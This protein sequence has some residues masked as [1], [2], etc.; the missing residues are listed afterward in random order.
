MEATARDLC[1]GWVEQGVTLADGLGAA[2]ELLP[3][4]RQ[5]LEKVEDDLARLDR[6]IS[7]SDEMGALLSGF[8]GAYIP[9]GPSGLITR[10]RPDI[11]PTGRNFYCPR[12]PD[13][14]HEGRLGDGQAPGGQDPRPV[15]HRRGRLPGEHRLLLAVHGY[16]V[17]RRGRHG[18]DDV[19]PRRKARLAGQRQGEGLSS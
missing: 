4:E 17:V 7:A 15:S 16:H 5:A 19:P 2:Y 1:K 10:G 3:S 13:H 11:L 12:P 8:D 6:S 18:P 9:P 14:S